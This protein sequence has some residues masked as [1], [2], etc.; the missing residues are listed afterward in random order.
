V[1]VLFNIKSAIPYTEAY[2]KPRVT[3]PQTKKS[4]LRN[5]VRGL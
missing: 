3:S 4:N 2:T 1:R 5:L